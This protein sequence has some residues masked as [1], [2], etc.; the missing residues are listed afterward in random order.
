M[1]ELRGVSIYEVANLVSQHIYGKP[2]MSVLGKATKIREGVTSFHVVIPDR[3]W[4]RLEQP[5]AKPQRAFTVK[6]DINNMIRH[7]RSVV[8]VSVTF[9]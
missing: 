4:S 8:K 6:E 3:I 1:I 5:R 2:Y 9:E 7:A